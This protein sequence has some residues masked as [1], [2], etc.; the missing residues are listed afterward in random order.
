MNRVT[1]AMIMLL[2]LLANWPVQAQPPADPTQT[3]PTAEKPPAGGI[4]TDFGDVA[5]DNLGIGRTYNLRDLVGMPMKVTNTGLDTVNLLI[6]VEI[7]QKD[8]IS[9]SHR[10]RGYSAVPSLN[11]VSL[12]QTQFV[13]PAGESAY[14][15]VI[16]TI[17]ND[18]TLYGKKFQTSIYSRTNQPGAINL[19]IFS[20]LFISIAKSEDEQKQIEGNHKRGI[21]GNMDYTLLPDKLVLEHASIGKKVDIRKET[22]RTIMIAN[23]GTEL[24]R[25]RVKSVPVGDTPLTLQTGFEAGKPEWISLKEPVVSVDGSSFAD[26]QISMDLPKDKSLI[27][28]KLM[29]VIKVEPADPEVVGV[30]FYGKIYVEVAQ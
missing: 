8:Q 17:P 11:W 22:K 24:I 13:V 4:K 29:F 27:G 30:T 21:V 12:S 16:I 25:L 19:G 14:S 20:H 7:P 1:R 23:S 6:S 5:I 28:K 10:E 15:D 9:E 3:G 26:P 2:T 18:P